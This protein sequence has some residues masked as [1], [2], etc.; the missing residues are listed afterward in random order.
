M[1]QTVD[2]ALEAGREENWRRFVRRH[3]RTRCEPTERESAEVIKQTGDG[4]FA[5]LD[6][7]RYPLDER[8][9][10]ALKGFERPVELVAVGWR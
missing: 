3:D 10:E 8:G 2:D 9:A 5:L 4:Y 6:A 1:T 7:S